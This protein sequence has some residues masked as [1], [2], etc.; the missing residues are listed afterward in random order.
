MSNIE[1][2]TTDND[3]AIHMSPLRHHWLQPLLFC[4]AKPLHNAVLVHADLSTLTQPTQPLLLA[5]WAARVL[6]QQ[7][8]TATHLGAAWR[9]AQRCHQSASQCSQPSLHSTASHCPLATC[10]LNL[11]TGLRCEL[12]HRPCLACP[13]GH[14]HLLLLFADL[15]L[16]TLAGPVA[17]SLWRT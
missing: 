2:C 12:L 5:L 16:H 10:Q 13:G 6:Q 3:L 14:V 8:P 4:T 15:C 7:P 17:S 11:L 1:Y 9:L